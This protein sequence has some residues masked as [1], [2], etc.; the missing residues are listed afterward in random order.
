MRSIISMASLA[1]AIVAPFAIWVSDASAQQLVGEG[2]VVGAK[3]IVRERQRDEGGTVT[4]RPQLVNESDE[5]KG[6]YELL[7]TN[8]VHLID[9][10]NKKK[11]L[12]VTDRSDSKCEC[13]DG[14]QLRTVSKDSPINLWPKVPAPPEDVRKLTVVVK[15]FDPVESV[16]I[17]AR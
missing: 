3:I 4:V 1:A 17:T 5:P 14:A 9:V 13:T 10:T 6:L 7:G 11:Y 8:W 12:V 16:P 2:E 15:S